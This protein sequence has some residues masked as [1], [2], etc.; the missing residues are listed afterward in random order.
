MR[1]H[2]QSAHN[3]KTPEAR[4]ARL[5]QMREHARIARSEETPEA[6][7][8]RLH[9]IREHAQTVCN[10]ESQEVRE[11]RLERMRVSAQQ[12]EASRLVQSRFDGITDT[13]PVFGESSV[14]KKIAKFHS[15]LADCAFFD[16]PLVLRHFHQ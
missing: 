1:E 8:A 14:Q 3:E 2:A 4:K 10:N 13:C 15:K 7:E 6:R 16:V 5:E 12:R 9:Q 11:S